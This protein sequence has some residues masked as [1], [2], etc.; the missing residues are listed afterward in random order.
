MTAI[1]AQLQAL[2]EV[3]APMSV[4]TVRGIML[5]VILQMGPQIVEHTVTDDSKFQASNYHV[6]GWLHDAMEWSSGDARGA[7]TAG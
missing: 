3:H 7:Q 5:A 6:R 4:V 2:R 1:K